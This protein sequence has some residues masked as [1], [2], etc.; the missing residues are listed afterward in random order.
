MA[1]LKRKLHNKLS[2]T[3]AAL[4]TDWVV[5]EPLGCLWRP[6][7]DSQLYPYLPPHITR[8][9]ELRRLYVISLPERCY[10]AV[11]WV[12][13]AATAFPVCILWLSSARS[14]TDSQLY[15][16]L[17][18]HITRP[19]KLRRLYVISLPERCYFA[20]SHSLLDAAAILVHNCSSRSEFFICLRI[21]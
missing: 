2:P 19:R 12:L 5:G 3:A 7:A 13:S 10:F 9:R 21:C 18:P 6:C 16:Y 20:V 8:P 11:S 1:G 14:C 15:P 17:P 4:R